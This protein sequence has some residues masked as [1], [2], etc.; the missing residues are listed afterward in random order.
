MRPKRSTSQQDALALTCARPQRTVPVEVG[1]H[2][3]ADDWRQELMPLRRLLIDHVLCGTAAAQRGYL[4]QHALL[5]Q[6]P[7]LRADVRTPDYCS[8]GGGE[9]P[10]TCNVWLGPAGTVTPLHHDPQHNLLCQAVGRKHVRLYAPGAGG[11]GA[12]YPHEGR[13]A[14]SSRVDALAPDASR[15]PL[16]A[17]AEFVDCE[18]APGDALYIPPRWWHFVSATTSSA[19]VSFWWGAAA[20]DN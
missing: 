1:E 12:L 18:L 6:I 15:F 13:C 20:A 16:F 8:L 17:A 3:L 14:N 10:P 11:D 4:A 2:Y 9:V 7:A 5:Q 19:S